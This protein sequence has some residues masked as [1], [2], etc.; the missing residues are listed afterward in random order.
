MANTRSQNGVTALRHVMDQLG[1]N[2]GSQ[3][4]VGLTQV[5]V[6]DITGLLLLEVEDFQLITV[7]TET[8]TENGILTSETGIDLVARHKLMA[9]K[10][11]Y[12]SQETRCIGTWHNFIQED[13]LDFVVN[14]E[15]T[16]QIQP[17]IHISMVNSLF[18]R[19]PLI[20]LKFN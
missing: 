2:V 3:V 9:V 16:P 6:M 8:E 15:P 5:G 20:T 13:F 19:A 14:E 10:I 18:L 12:P 4:E 1:F 11:W 7:T 17:P